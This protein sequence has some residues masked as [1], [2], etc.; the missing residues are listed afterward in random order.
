[1]DKAKFTYW[2]VWI[3]VSPLLLV[4]C[5]YLSIVQFVAL[6]YAVCLCMSCSLCAPSFRTSRTL[7]SAMVDM[8]WHV[9]L[10]GTTEG[11]L[12]RRA[13]VTLCEGLSAPV[14]SNG[15]LAPSAWVKTYSRCIISLWKCFYHVLDSRCIFPRAVPVPRFLL[16]TARVEWLNCVGSEPTL[17]SCSYLSFLCYIVISY[18]SWSNFGTPHI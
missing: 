18:M 13:S 4:F 2:I 5:L 14:W 10:D 12:L 11:H 9:N 8:H 1:M 7:T 16:G 17:K 6:R 15:D 3:S